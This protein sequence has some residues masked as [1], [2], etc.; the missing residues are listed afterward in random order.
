MAG[1]RD[2]GRND[3]LPK[4]AKNHYNIN[5]VAKEFLKIL[6]GVYHNEPVKSPLYG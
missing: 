1:L 3:F 4:E 2:R 5:G 6:K